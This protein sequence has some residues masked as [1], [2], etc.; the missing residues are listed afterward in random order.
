MSLEVK[1]QAEVKEVKRFTGV[2]PF[3]VIAINPSKAQLEALEVNVK[4]EPTYK[5]NKEGVDTLR[6]DFWLR[7]SKMCY[8]DLDGTVVNYEWYLNGISGTPITT[9]SFT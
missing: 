5:G 1:K 3:Q 6:V 2:I 9:K 7:N 8:T 4:E